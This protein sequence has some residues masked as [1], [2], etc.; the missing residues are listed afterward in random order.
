MKISDLYQNVTDTIIKQLEEGSAPWVRPWKLGNPGGTGVMPVNGAT[1]RPYSGINIPMLWYAK[2]MRGFKTPRWMTFRQALL[3]GAHVRKGETGTT[4]VFTKRIMVKRDEE[5]KQIGMLRTF[6]VFNVEQIEGLTPT[7]GNSEEPI[8]VNLDRLDLF[9]RAT[10]AD[11]HIG[12]D[13]AC[14][15]PSRDFVLMPPE[16]AFKSR[17]HF[18]ATELHELSHWTGHQT[19]L[20]RDLKGRF[21]TKDYAAEELIAELSAAF[22]CAH[23]GI[24][25]ELRHAEYIGNWLQLLKAD[26]RAIFT[27]ASK[28]SQAA[29]YLRSFSETVQEEAA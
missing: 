11:I 26:N 13:R 10:Q 7:T 3:L 6:V 4:V 15:V 2:E 16:A 17:E 28:A 23:L 29:D 14:Y 18:L 27:A 1:N 19:R 24:Q 9:V 12:G 22:L 25:G 20:A 8:P 5:D 21:G